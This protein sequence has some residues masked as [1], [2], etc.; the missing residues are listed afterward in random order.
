MSFT[1]TATLRVTDTLGN[2]TNLSASWSGTLQPETRIGLLRFY[3]PKTGRWLSRDRIGERGGLNLYGFVLNNPLFWVDYLGWNPTPVD[4][5][6]SIPNGSSSQNNLFDDVAKRGSD[7]GKNQRVNSGEELLTF[8][9]ELSKN[10]CCIQTLT[11]AGHGW[12]GPTDG[13]GIPGVAGGSGLYRDGSGWA[14]PANGGRSIQDL[15]DSISKG[16][17]KFCSPCTIQIH[18]CSIS[19][20]F[21]SDLASA[22]GCRV[23]AAGGGCDRPLPNQWRS[24]AQTGDN[25]NNPSNEFHES[26]PNGTQNDIGHTYNPR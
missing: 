25:G 3:N 24:T 10:S 5:G 12:R 26:F 22:T 9:T 1:V 4:G 16:D 11:I 19:R 21:G 8:L 13:P 20:E 18:A 6:A 2:Q 17:V 7:K 23:V 15:K 14:D